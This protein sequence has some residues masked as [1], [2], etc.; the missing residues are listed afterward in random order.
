MRRSA[1]E[2]SIVARVGDNELAV[3]L[4]GIPEDKAYKIAESIKSGLTAAVS[5]GVASS[6]D[7][8]I[9]FSELLRESF[10]SMECAGQG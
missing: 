1:G 5:I 6:L 2:G 4:P 3:L 8:R 7:G 10:D 9:D